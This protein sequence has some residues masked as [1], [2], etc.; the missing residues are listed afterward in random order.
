[1]KIKVLVVD[2]NAVQ[3]ELLKKYFNGSDKINIV[4]SAS[5]GEEAIKLLEK[6]T[7]YDIM[8]LD[9]VMPIKDGFSVLDYM[10]E[11]SINKSIIVLSA[12]NEEETI[13]RVSEYGVKYYALKP[14]NLSK[15]EDVMIDI[16]KKKKSNDE[17]VEISN[18]DLQIQVTRILHALGIPSNIKGYQY[19]RSA[20]LKVYDNPGFIG[21]I[22]KE[23]YPDLSVKFNTSV[24]RVERAIRHAIEVSWLRG[25]IDLMEEIFGHSVD[26]D[27]AKPTNSEFIVTIADKMRL[28]MINV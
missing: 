22:T 2:D 8:L 16:C 23:L 14:F 27:R 6:E 13:R 15:L 25:D 9:I 3:V 18:K 17:L 4:A 11:S 28:D 20:I 10:K 19:I 5:N 7:D 12:F 26:I 24:G 21:G 1:M